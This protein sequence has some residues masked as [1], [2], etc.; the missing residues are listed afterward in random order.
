MVYA[1]L[2]LK[3]SLWY[4]DEY[5][6]NVNEKNYSRSCK[7]HKI[8]GFKSCIWEPKKPK[9]LLLD[10]RAIDN[11]LLKRLQN[12]KNIPDWNLRHSYVYFSSLSTAFSMFFI[13]YDYYNYN[14]FF[15]SCYYYVNTLVKPEDLINSKNYL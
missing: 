13:S 15:V 5:S 12:F 8:I 3:G 6:W 9:I 11:F 1:F 2:N 4:N 14:G 7:K 10:S